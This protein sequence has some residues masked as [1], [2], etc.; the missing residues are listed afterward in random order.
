MVGRDIETRI[1]KEKEF[2]H[3]FSYEKKIQEEKKKSFFF[4]ALTN[5]LEYEQKKLDNPNILIEGKE[6]TK[7]EKF[8]HYVKV[9]SLKYVRPYKKNQIKRYTVL[10]EKSLDIKLDNED[11]VKRLNEIINSRLFGKNEIEK[12]INQKLS[13]EKLLERFIRKEKLRNY[14]PVEEFKDYFLNKADKETDINWPN[15]LLV[16]GYSK[17]SKELLKKESPRKPEI[18]EDTIL[19]VENLTVIS[20]HTKKSVIDN[21]SFSVKKGEIVCIAGIDGNG[22]SELAYTI[23]GMM[24]SNGGN[25]YLNGENI[26]NKSTRYRNDNGISH[27]PEN[28][29]EDG[30]FMNLSLADNLA[31]K[32]YHQKPYQKFGFINKKPIFEH[33]EKLIPIYDIRSGEGAKS[34]VGPMS[35]GN[36]Q[37]AIIAREI[38]KDSD[39][40]LAVQT[41]RGLD[42]GAIEFV[43]KK[44]VE[45]RDRGKAVLMV[46]FE[47]EEV[48]SISDRILVMFEGKIVGDLKPSE[49]TVEELG[50]YMAGAKHD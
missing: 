28:R 12:K 6:L 26:T 44:I 8:L 25:I 38:D 32:V 42:V 43:H 19:L 4:N 21:V 30:L 18:S 1:E 50:L 41:V 23:S 15:N 40:L 29:Q 22:Q 17:F 20:P 37:K 24:R 16:F 7:R 34:I 47:L 14:L 31:M 13:K 49:I 2:E 48:M 35:G 33:A 39:L 3:D 45:E 11:H 46:S 10:A 9:Y 36:Q 5:Y 27:I